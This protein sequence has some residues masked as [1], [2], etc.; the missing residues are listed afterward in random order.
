[1]TE[2]SNR[3]IPPP[4]SWEEFENLCCDLWAKILNDS[5]TSKN[6][7]SGQAQNGVDIFG[8]RDGSGAWVGVQCKGKDSRY[9][10]EVTESELKEEVK[11][12][13]KEAETHGVLGKGAVPPANEMFNHV[14]KEMPPHLRKQRQEAGM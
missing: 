14:Y 11:A 5:T 1:V 9:K 2:F 6:G 7:R 12:A 10:K 8:R 4:L 3:Q 13:A